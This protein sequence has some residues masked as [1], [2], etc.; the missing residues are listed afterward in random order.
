MRDQLTTTPRTAP[1]VRTTLG[2]RVRQLRIAKGL[3][4][5]E[6]AGERFGRVVAVAQ[7]GGL[8]LHMDGARLMNA[9]VASGVMGVPELVEDGKSGLLVPP[10]R[11]RAL[12]DALARLAES[13]ELRL[14]LGIGDPHETDTEVR[15]PAAFRWRAWIEENGMPLPVDERLVAVAE[16]EHV[17]LLGGGRGLPDAGDHPRCDVDVGQLQDV[18]VADLTGRL[19]SQRPVRGDPDLQRRRTRPRE[20]QV[21]ALVVHRPAV[22]ELADHLRRNERV[23]IIVFAGPEE[24][25]MVPLMKKLFPAGTILFDRLTIPQLAAALARL[26]VFVSN[27]TGPAHTAAAVGTPVVVIMDR[28]T[29]NNFMPVGDHHRLIGAEKITLVSV[30]QVYHAAREVLAANRIDKLSSL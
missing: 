30:N 24:R 6:L 4:Q 9:V 19:E 2:D 27:D 22:G 12:A 10:G 1:A 8:R 15:I 5:T 3:T 28:P 16:D 21:G 20:L 13:S 25:Q 11:P 18:A 29:P 23:R 7:E 14:E 26:T 17:G